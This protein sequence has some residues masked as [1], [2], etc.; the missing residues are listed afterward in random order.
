M[1]YC[2]FKVNDK[3]FYGAV[4]NNDVTKIDGDIFS[5]YT[6]TDDKYNI[7]ELELLTP[8][9]PKKIVAVGKN[10]AAH[11]EELDGVV[12]DEPCLF[13]MPTTAI[14]PPNGYIVK[15]D[16]VTRMDYEGELAIVIKKTCKNVSKEEAKDYV[17]GYTC[18]NDVTARDIQQRD[19]QWTRGKGMDTFAPFGPIIT[20]EVD[21]SNLAIETKVNNEVKQKSNTNMMMYDVYSIISFISKSFTLEPGDVIATGTPEGIGP[22]DSGDE[23]VVTI[24]G[25]GSLIN[26]VK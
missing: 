18:L 14:L 21:P 25:I 22:M 16:F 4:Y 10:Y 17:L 11:A 15:P 5:E 19:G 6:L 26:F 12:P 7:N 23:V 20:D 24:E 9:L 3:I 1:K 13:L 8:V 2:R